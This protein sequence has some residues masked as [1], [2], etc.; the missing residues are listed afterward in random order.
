MMFALES[1]AYGLKNELA[2]NGKNSYLKFE[3]SLFFPI[4]R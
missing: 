3:S 1:E 4:S 2:N